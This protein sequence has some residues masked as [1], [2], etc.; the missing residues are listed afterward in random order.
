[1][2]CQKCGKELK[3]DAKACGSCEAETG[4]LETVTGGKKLLGFAVQIACAIVVGVVGYYIGLVF[5]SY[6]FQDR[7]FKEIVE[8]GKYTPMILDPD[9]LSRMGPAGKKLEETAAAIGWL[10][11][12]FSALLIGAPIGRLI[13]R[14]LK[15][16]APKQKW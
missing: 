12:I 11:G 15:F 16:V 1:M 3:G 10:V 7:R 13:A 4:A 5:I 14:G 6:F 2:F 8:L 9:A